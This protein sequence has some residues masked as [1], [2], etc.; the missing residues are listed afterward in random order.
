M[1]EVTVLWAGKH[2]NA[3]EEATARHAAALM[4]RLGS[5]TADH[6]ERFLPERASEWT[7][8]ELELGAH[9]GPWMTFG[10]DAGPA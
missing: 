3:A 5:D 6:L 2:L 1:A 7:P 9:V 4:R 8:D 10:A